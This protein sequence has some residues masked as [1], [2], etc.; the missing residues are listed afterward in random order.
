MS[1]NLYAHDTN[2]GELKEMVRKESKLFSVNS[3][4][5]FLMSSDFGS[6]TINDWDQ[7]EVSIEVQ[8]VATGTDDDD[9][10]AALEATQIRMQGTAREVRM[11][12]ELPNA[13][14]RGKSWWK[15]WDTNDSKVRVNVIVNMPRTGSMNVKHDFGD[16]VL[17]DF[18]GNVT[19]Q[20]DYGKILAGRLTGK[21]T[22]LRFDYTKNSEFD[23]ISNGIIRADYSD[24]TVRE[25]GT[26]NVRADFT[27]SNIN[28]MNGELIYAGDYGDLR[29]EYTST[30]NF[31]GD[32]V[33]VRLG[34][35]A[36][37]TIIRASYGSLRIADLDKNFGS[38]SIRSDFTSGRIAYGTDTSFTFDTDFEFAD[39]DLEGGTITNRVK[40]MTEKS[41]NGFVGNDG[42]SN[43]I[44]IDSEY[45]SYKIVQQ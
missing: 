32:Y 30:M 40:D 24:F 29:T 18:T 43:E 39:L 42:S 1:S 44:K 2:D 37:P 31:R 8:V 22:N 15:F 19:V 27:N 33:T 12:S 6:V 23:L 13:G 11:E 21:E 10:K 3:D 45:G 28:R 34:T 17:G 36:G 20:C 26:L 25:A 35:V 5:A 41:Y 4:V 7:N 9:L 38:L 14:N 16:L